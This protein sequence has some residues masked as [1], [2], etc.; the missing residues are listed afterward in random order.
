MAASAAVVSTAPTWPSLE[1]GVNRLSALD[2]LSGY[3]NLIAAKVQAAKALSSAPV[4]DLSKAHM[5]VGVDGLPSPDEGT[6]VRHVAVGRGTQNYTCDPNNADAAPKTAG[7]KATLF[8]ASCIA[9][10][11]PDILSSISGMAVH[12]KLE[13]T[14]RLGPTVMAKSGVHY[15]SDSSTPFF[16]LD[17]SK[18]EIGQVPCAKN[19][20]SNAPST[21][22]VGQLGEKAVTW[23]RLTT[24]DG[25]TGDIKDVYRVDTAGGSPPATCKDMPA[26]FEVEY[27]AVYWFWQGSA[28]N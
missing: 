9:A 6:T 13:E 8:N 15:F 27:A 26:K 20:S 4:C 11:Y 14:E 17:T 25:T 23:L 10:L 19:S 16:N 22:A 28:K 3:F 7:A 24:K 21:A 18:E 2:N 1:L 5:P 12:F